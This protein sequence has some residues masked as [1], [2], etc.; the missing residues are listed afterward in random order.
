MFTAD[1]FSELDRYNNTTTVT[2][3]S[4]DDG[5]T[6]TVTMRGVDLHGTE[7]VTVKFD[8]G[9]LLLYHGGYKTRTTKKRMNEALT[10]LDMGLYV[11]KIDGDFYLMNMDNDEVIEKFD[12]D[13]GLM[14]EL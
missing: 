5:S 4:D 13:G 14:Y 10:S 7:I 9:V 2:N 12:D 8:R 6:K 3:Y 11:K 1:S